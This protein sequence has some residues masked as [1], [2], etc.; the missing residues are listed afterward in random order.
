[1]GVLHLLLLMLGATVVVEAE[2]DAKCQDALLQNGA[3]NSKAN[4]NASGVS[5]ASTRRKGDGGAD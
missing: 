5:G 3:L 2:C 1:M 4:L